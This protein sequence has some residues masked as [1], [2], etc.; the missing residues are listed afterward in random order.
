MPI[1]G[2]KQRLAWITA[3]AVLAM[4]PAAFCAIP[5]ASGPPAAANTQ[6]PEAV[7]VEELDV[8]EEVVVHGKR[9][10]EQIYEA[11]DE[12]YKVFNDINKDDRYDTHCVS[13]QL[14]RESRIQSRACMPGFVADAMADWAPYKARCQPPMEGG[15]E[16]TCLDRNRDG[17]LSRDEAAARVELDAAFVDLD[18]DRGPDNYLSRNELDASCSDCDPSKIPPIEPVYIPPTPDI[19]LANGSKKWYDHMKAV[20]DS[21]PRLVKMADHLGELYQA[22]SAAQ[23]RYDE[24]DAEAKSKAKRIRSVRVR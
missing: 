19:V 16:F 5:A 10:R 1:K 20:I 3:A 21:D 11:E 4:V 18:V 6:P 23:H 12:F 2:L 24:L 8:L 9:L 14:D 7:A 17:R 13:L 15:D 22:L